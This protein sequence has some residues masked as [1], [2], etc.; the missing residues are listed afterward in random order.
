MT[1]DE[2]WADLIARGELTAVLREAGQNDT[3]VLRDIYALVQTFAPADLQESMLRK[4]SAVGRA[5][6]KTEERLAK[7]AGTTPAPVAPDATTSAP[8]AVVEQHVPPAAAAA[9]AGAPRR[10]TRPARFR[11][12]HSAVD[13][14]RAFADSV[15]A[16]LDLRAK[17]ENRPAPEITD[18]EMAAGLRAW[19]HALQVEGDPLR[20]VSWTG[21]TAMCLAMWLA[22]RYP[23]ISRPVPISSDSRVWAL[24]KAAHLSLR[25]GWLDMELPPEPGRLAVELDVNAQYLAAMSSAQLGDGDPIELDAAQLADWDLLDLVKLPGYL[26]LGSAPDLSGLPPHA[27]AVFARLTPGD[28]LPT[29]LATYLAR[30]HHVDLD[31]VEAI[32]WH[33]VEVLD[34]RTRKTTTQAAYGKRCARWAKTVKEGRVTLMTAA[35]GQPEN[36]PAQ[37]ALLLLKRLYSQF[38]ALLRSPAYN[39]DSRTRKPTGWLR[40]DWFDMLLA[41]ANANALR[42]L[43][44]LVAAGWTVHGGLRDS[45][46]ITA[47]ALADINGVTVPYLRDATGALT[48]LTAIEISTRP[49]MWKISRAVRITEDLLTTYRRRRPKTWREALQAAEHHQGAAA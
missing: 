39:V 1:N 6:L 35:A 11:D 48:P 14:Q 10:G 8:A 21:W 36:H 47:D 17:R 23:K 34:P 30:D 33:T 24:S 29:P 44:K 41:T 42:A 37:L 20:Y 22:D 16:E 43:D 38:I 15:R 19:H 32:V 49:G 31:V 7:E 4:V 26:V 27:R 2:T 13:E 45:I 12:R 3:G 28:P 9:A 40:P 25:F 46:W 5:A 18:D